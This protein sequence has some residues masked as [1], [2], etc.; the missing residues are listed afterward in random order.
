MAAEG[1]GEQSGERDSRAL[2]NVF[3]RLASQWRPDRAFDA[4]QQQRKTAL[5]ELEHV[6]SCLAQSVER[7]ADIHRLRAVVGW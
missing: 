1:S 4:G 3:R 7:F 2:R 6:Q 5:M